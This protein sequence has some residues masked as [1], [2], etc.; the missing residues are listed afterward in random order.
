MLHND[1]AQQRPGEK[2]ASAPKTSQNSPWAQGQAKFKIPTLN[3]ADS[4][5][6]DTDAAGLKDRNMETSHIIHI[7]CRQSPLTR[8]LLTTPATTRIL[9]HPQSPTKI[10]RQ[11]PMLLPQPARYHSF[12]EGHVQARSVLRLEHST[13]QKQLPLHETEDLQQN[14]ERSKHAQKSAEPWLDTRMYLDSHTDSD[15]HSMHSAPPAA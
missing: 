8:L 6:E 2:P 3:R 11:E 7:H 14:L 10:L 1:T 9:Q 4:R 5:H 15:T 12:G 13:E